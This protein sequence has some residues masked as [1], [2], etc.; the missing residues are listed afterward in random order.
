MEPATLDALLNGSD[1]PD[2]ATLYAF[3]DAVNNV[4]SLTP[5]LAG[6]TVTPAQLMGIAKLPAWIARY[7]LLD[8]SK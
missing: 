8:S 1:T 3:C 5:E 6:E 7:G 4:L 2:H